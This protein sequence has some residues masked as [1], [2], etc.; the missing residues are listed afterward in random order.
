MSS[1]WG[2]GGS[3]AE[4]RGTGRGMRAER[5]RDMADTAQVRRGCCRC[6]PAPSYPV[7]CPRKVGSMLCSTWPYAPMPAPKSLSVCRIGT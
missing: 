1:V 7:H 4:R 3:I 5:A 6:V 2:R